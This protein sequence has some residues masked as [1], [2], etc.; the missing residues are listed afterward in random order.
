MGGVGKMS[1]KVLVERDRYCPKKIK[2]ADEGFTLIEVLIAITIFS[3][4][5]LAVA[6][7]Q[8]SAIY[9]NQTGNEFSQAVGLAQMKAED[10][11]TGDFTSASL[12]VS[13]G[14]IADPNNPLDANGNSGGIFTRSWSISNNTTFSRSI[15]IRV[16]WA[17]RG[18]PHRVVLTTFTRGGGI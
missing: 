12:A 13:G 17:T 18:I 16:A 5:L 9:G 11:K 10:L 14:Y 8:I 7:M 1:I 15:I 3:V 2:F 4:G 6:T